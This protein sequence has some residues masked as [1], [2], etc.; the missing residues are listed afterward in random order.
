MS[1]VGKRVVDV[2]EIA[3]LKY[4]LGVRKQDNFK[5]I[6]VKL[7]DDWEIPAKLFPEG[8][9]IK[10]SESDNG[11]SILSFYTET[12]H[13]SDIYYIIL[14]VIKYNKEK[15]EKITSLNQLQ[16]L[17]QKYF[18]EMDLEQ[19]KTVTITSKVVLGPT[20]TGGESGDSPLPEENK[21]V[22]PEVPEED[23]SRLNE[24]VDKTKKENDG[25][26]LKP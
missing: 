13:F 16:M 10:I 18:E 11:S 6:D 26:I 14:D 25:T 23:R 21:R 3:E 15:E 7:P 24:G 12:E 9:P 1:T 17:L 19:F 20:G 8:T 22:I 5:V 4:V 2:D